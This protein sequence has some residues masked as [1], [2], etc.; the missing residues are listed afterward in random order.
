MERCG[1]W[2]HCRRLFDYLQTSSAAS[3]ATN[4]IMQIDTICQVVVSVCYANR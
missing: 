2:V 1:S 4:K 3:L